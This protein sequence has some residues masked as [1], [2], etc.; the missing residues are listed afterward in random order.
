MCSEPS[1]AMRFPKQRWLILGI[2]WLLSVISFGGIQM[3]S[4]FSFAL[5]PD[6][7]LS[8]SQ[9][10]LIFTAPTLMAMFACVPGGV[11][12]D[13]FGPRPIVALGTLCTGVFGFL[14]IFSSSFGFM[15]AMM[16]LMGISMGFLFPNLPKVVGIWFPRRELGLASGIYNTGFGMASA[17]AFATTVPIY[18]S[19]WR[20]G[21]I[22]MAIASTAI[23]FVWWIFARNAPR[24]VKVPPPPPL[25][26]G[27]K[28]SLQSKNI[29][30]VS[31]SFAAFMGGFYSLAGIMPRALERVHNVN[32]ST[33]GW[34]LS[35]FTLGMVTGH[36]IW[37]LLS[38]RLGRRKPFVY[39]GAVFCAIA[40]FLSWYTAFGPWTFALM[41][42][43][44]V[45]LGAIPPILLAL[46]VELPEIKHEYAG[47]AA[48]IV[49]SLGNA[50]G[51]LIPSFLMPVLETPDMNRTFFTCSAII[52]IIV[53]LNIFIMET[54]TRV[55]LEPRQ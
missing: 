1:G 35:V 9:F 41:L 30:F 10:L 53:I 32:P 38:D 31:F 16:L 26:P 15:F 40:L 14:R 20:L 25:M 21:F 28:A 13:R 54:G 48:G 46:P 45:A 43:S 8:L 2:A 34:V 12:G 36:I 51:F 22:V 17:Y 24:G 29:W 49:T 6:L 11:L 7:K 55:E 42:T 47:T 3:I 18:G 23:G 50:S 4:P 37:P 27:L 33:A 39:I 5:M 44:G 52:G 19:N